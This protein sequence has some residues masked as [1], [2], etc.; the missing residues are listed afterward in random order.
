MSSGTRVPQAVTTE[1]LNQ[2]SHLTT[3]QRAAQLDSWSR[4]TSGKVSASTMRQEVQGR[5]NL[6]AN[7]RHLL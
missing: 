2:M 1:S 7:P 5:R 4:R 3:R 6:C